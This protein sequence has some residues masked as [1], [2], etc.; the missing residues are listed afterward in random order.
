MTDPR[1]GVEDIEDLRGTGLA[2]ADL[3]ELYALATECTVAFHS[4]TGWPGGVRMSYLRHDGRF[5]LTA[6]A[7][8]DHVESLRADPRLT[9]VVDNGGTGLA[10]RRMV[11]VRA[12]A[13]LHT[14]RAVK[15]WFYPAFAT[16]LQ[17]ADPAA[18]I[19]LLDSPRRVVLE[20]VPTGGQVSHD[21]RRIGG[22]GR[23]S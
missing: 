23:G 7:G 12:I 15:D 18:F 6:V 9:L 21:S 10:G 1:L 8:R 5:W 4:R 14:E 11:A 19:R 22:D 20:A 3:A 16:R 2:A 17:V 13:I